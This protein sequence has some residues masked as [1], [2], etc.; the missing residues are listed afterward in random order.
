MA[1]VFSILIITLYGIL[2][3]IFTV[4]WFRMKEAKATGNTNPGLFLSIIIPVRN[5]EAN[6]LRLLESLQKQTFPHYLFEI[7]VVDDHSTDRTLSLATKFREAHPELIMQI[8]QTRESGKT[9]TY[10]KNA[11]TQA[12]RVA[13]GELIITTDGDTVAEPQWLREIASY[14]RQTDAKMIVGPVKY[15]DEQ[16]IFEKLQSIE[17]LSLIGITAGALGIRLPLMCNGAN[18]AYRKSAFEDVNGYEGDFFTSGDDVML[19]LKIKK[20][21]GAGSIR[22]LK[23]RQAFVRTKAQK[24]LP[25]FLVQRGRWASKNKHFQPAISAVA[26]LVFLTNLI[27]L[28]YGVLA[29][30]GQIAF[31]YYLIFWVAKML[32]DFPLVAGILKFAKKWRLSVFFIPLAIVYPLYIVSSAIYGMF[33]KFTWKGR[34]YTK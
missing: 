27:L 17:F 23:S 29:L 31:K 5:E 21:F 13:A 15:T 7:I 14:Y 3:G 25:D 6:I 32:I 9:G 26:L 20:K 30:A 4:S 16:N 11:I 8:I 28:L 24:T 22:F 10:K 19:M 2:I 33:G 12:I 34:V 18:L 1:V